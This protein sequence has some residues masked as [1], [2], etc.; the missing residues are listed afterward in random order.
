[1]KSVIVEGSSLTNRHDGCHLYILLTL[2]FY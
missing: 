1:M 2:H